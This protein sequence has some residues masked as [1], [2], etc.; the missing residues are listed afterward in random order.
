MRSARTGSLTVD[1]EAVEAAEDGSPGAVEDSDGKE[2]TEAVEATEEVV[3]E[4]AEAGD[5]RHPPVRKQN[6]LSL[7]YIY[8]KTVKKP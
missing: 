4:A 8:Q 1:V 2:G 5:E 7:F 3:D 6:V